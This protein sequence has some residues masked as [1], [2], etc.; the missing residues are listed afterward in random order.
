[1]ILSFE[2]VA[3]VA[4]IVTFERDVFIL[5]GFLIDGEFFKD[6][7]LDFRGYFVMGGDLSLILDRKTAGIGPID[8]QELKE[9]CFSDAEHGLDIVSF[10]SVAKV[11]FQHLFDLVVRKA[12]VK[13]AHM[14]S[15]F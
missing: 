12:F 7:L 1:M 13:L 6:V 5:D 9:S 10:D 3:D 2:A 14:L 8:L 15:S 4:V 11:T